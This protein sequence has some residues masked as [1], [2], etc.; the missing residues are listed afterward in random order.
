M[1]NEKTRQSTAASDD[2]SPAHRRNRFVQRQIRM[3]GNQRQ[4]PA[5]VLLQWRNASATRL[6]CR[7][8]VIAPAPEPVDHR[9]RANFKKRGHL[10]SRSATLDDRYRSRPQVVR[11][12]LG[13][14]L[15]LPK[16]IKGARLA[17]PQTFGNPPDST[18]TGYALVRRAGPPGHGPLPSFKA[19][20]SKQIIQS[21][22]NFHAMKSRPSLCARRPRT[23]TLCG[24]MNS[25]PVGTNSLV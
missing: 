15:I 6:R 2:P 19:N 16:R 14:P 24:G 4:Q 12:R 25:A 17:H 7:A 1:P 3:L 5:R 21:R 13:H 20:H 23:Q 10:V 8:A 9:T 22:G 18:P 11:I